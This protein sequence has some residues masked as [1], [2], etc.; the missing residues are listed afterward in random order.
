MA[1]RSPPRPP[2][3]PFCH[4]NSVNRV[5]PSREPSPASLG[6][7]YCPSSLSVRKMVAIQLPEK[8]RQVV[9]GVEEERALKEGAASL[10][11]CPAPRPGPLAGKGAL[12][13][14]EK[15]LVQVGRG[16]PC[17]GGMRAPP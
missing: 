11:P 4:H 6:L 3:V 7:C 13:L 10:G 14:A 1:R 9:P 2:R 12:E 15:P 5:N 17:R 8:G 16:L